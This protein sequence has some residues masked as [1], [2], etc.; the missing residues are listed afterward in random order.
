MSS[1]ERFGYEWDKYNF[2]DPIYETQFLNW[3]SPLTK[4]DF[5]NKVI[6]DAGCGMGRNSFW[7]LRYGAE[8]VTAIDFDGRSVDRAKK[9]LSSF[10]N[11]GVLFR[12]IYDIDWEESFDMTFSIGVIHHLEHPREAIAKLV[13]SLK[14]GGTLLLWV[15]S[16]EGNEWIVRHVNPV[17][18]NI[19]S[20]LPVSLVHLL[21]Y[22]C[23]VPLW[24]FAKL[25][26]NVNPYIKQISTFKF[27]HLHSIVF[28]QLIP[29]VAN[30]W[31]KEEV[32]LLFAGLD[33]SDIDVHSPPNGNGWTVIATKNKL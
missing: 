26:K 25:F 32:E 16:Y 17:R 5:K 23:S 4:N 21:S 14:T 31:K 9:N 6:L 27:W 3:V 2:V 24:L 1:Q 33:L 18:K 29:E 15:Y 30:Y 13:R 28:D 19:T 10:S 7:A 22:F 8:K 20:K 11:A 12:S